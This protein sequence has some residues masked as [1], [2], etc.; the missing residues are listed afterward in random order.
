MTREEALLVR[1]IKKGCTYRRLAEIWF[2]SPEHPLHGLRGNQLAGE[3]LCRQ[4]CAA[5]GIDWMHPPEYGDDP[6][7]DAENTSSVGEFYWWD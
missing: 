7:F 3:D 5:L 1:E 6:A 4:A 2:D